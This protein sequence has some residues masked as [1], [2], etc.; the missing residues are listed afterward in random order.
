M[1]ICGVC[2]CVCFWCV[3]VLT[4]AQLQSLEAIAFAR[5]QSSLSYPDVQ[6]H[7]VASGGGEKKGAF[8]L[9]PCL[10]SRVSEELCFVGF[11]C[12]S[13]RHVNIV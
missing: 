13:L 6:L 1:C 7:C 11:L 4:R 9:F 2:V 10:D 12:F 5:T 3:C 8:S